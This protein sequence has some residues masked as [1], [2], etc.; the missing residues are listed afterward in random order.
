MPRVPSNSSP[1]FR[2][3]AL[4][5][6]AGA[7]VALIVAGFIAFEVALHVSH[8]DSS[9]LPPFTPP[10]GA[11]PT[12]T[13]SL[14]ADVGRSALSRVVTIEAVLPNEES[15][16]TGWLLDTHGDF[17]TNAHVVSG[18]LAVRITDRQAHVHVA[19]VLGMDLAADI[20]VVRS[21]DGFPGQPLAVSSVAIT[22]VPVSVVALASSRATGQVDLTPDTISNLHEDVPL[23]S[24]GQ[25]S[26]PPGAPSVYHD[27]LHLT[28]AHVFE[29]NSGGPVLDVRGEVVGIVTLAD[30]N[31]PDAYA[32]PLS[33][34]LAELNSFAA[35][36][37]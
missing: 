21:T 31:H 1:T 9:A 19:T 12:P 7:V 25:S 32:I 18:Q 26:P 24:S 28:G 27:M 6:A 3:N 36:S 13:P 16:G 2:R 37:G 15:L 14:L 10:P 23:N 17:V 35:R 29:G 34:V 33:R 5:R 22:G 8:V 30:P 4:L 20:A 11:S